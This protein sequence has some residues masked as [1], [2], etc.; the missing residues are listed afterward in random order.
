MTELARAHRKVDLL[1]QSW[2]GLDAPPT[3]LRA[4]LSA[5]IARTLFRT[6]VH[7]LD[8]TV[9]VGDHTYGRGGPVMVVTRPEEFYLRLGFRPTG[10]ELFGQVVGELVV[11]PRE[12]AETAGG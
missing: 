9:H 5:R 2:P 12:Q 3:G 8:V 10:E 11:A 4:R 7:G 6:A 1:A